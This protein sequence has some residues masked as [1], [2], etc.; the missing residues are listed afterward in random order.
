[1]K[2][3][4][5]GL[6]GFGVVGSGV[7]KA[8]QG[9]S[10]LI[11]SRTGIKLKLRKVADL[12]LER[13][14]GVSLPAGVLT[15][16]A[17]SVIRDPDIDLIIELIGGVSDAGRLTIA[18]LRAG[19]PVVTANKALLAERGDEIF[20]T[21]QEC[22]TDVFFEASVGGGM[23]L[24]HSL[25]ESMVSNHVKTIYGILNGTCNFILTRMEQDGLSF[26]DALDEARRAG[27]AE[28][29]P[30]LDI[31]GTDTAH[32]AA[33]LASLVYGFRVAMKRVHVEGIR[34]LSID[35]IRNAS[36]L[37][38]RVKML[39]VIKDVDGRV[40]VRA[41]PA[42]IPK[43]G[44]M[45]SVGGEYNAVLLNGDGVGDLLWYGKGAGRDPTASAV[46]SDVVDA[47]RDLLAG[48]PRRAPGVIY[49]NPDC[50]MLDVG[51]SSV[52][53]YL[54]LTLLDKPGVFGQIA[55]V[56]GRHGISIASLLQ[57]EARSG[58]QVPVIVI[59]HHAP[60]KAYGAAIAE[61]DEMPVVGAE[62]VRFR[63]EDC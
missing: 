48:S 61:I 6:L 30:G 60:E 20:R 4:G 35:D 14:R 50:E 34:S 39:A 57:K 17:E 55:S 13:D 63:I 44:V 23:P 3:I 9:K 54:R 62:T 53:C 51:E 22:G 38:Y 15:S 10:G 58:E 25:R 49:Y 32:K 42:L 43:E 19:K 41:H 5:L 47:A 21:A 52:R 46:L 28:A 24:I 7:I 16:D 12:D 8:L 11:A 36:G 59:T 29:D 18:A 37:G 27:F 45:A 31:D 2:E 33:I 26:D 56:L 1:M 40:E